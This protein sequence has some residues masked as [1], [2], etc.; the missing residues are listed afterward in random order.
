ME[1]SLEKESF[2]KLKT[3]AMHLCE[4]AALVMAYSAKENNVIEISILNRLIGNVTES[5]GDLDHRL[6]GW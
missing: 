1:N 6:S 3:M 2:N 5:I 4:E